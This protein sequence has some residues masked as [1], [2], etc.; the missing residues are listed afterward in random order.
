VKKVS[1]QEQA[2]LLLLGQKLKK[3]RKK[4]GHTQQEVA[5][6]LDTDYSVIGRLEAGGT[7]PTTITLRR[8]AE[9]LEVPLSE[10][11]KDL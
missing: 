1:E 11:F 4:K 6:Y 7:N 8:I 5:D 9:Y 10:I 2:F 3:E